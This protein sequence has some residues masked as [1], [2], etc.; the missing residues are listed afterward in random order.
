M[1]PAGLEPASATVTECR[2]PLTLR[3]LER[4]FG[5]AANMERLAETIFWTVLQIGRLLLGTG[6]LRR[7]RS[8]LH[9]L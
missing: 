8:K 9:A 7:V 2:V 3:A 1:D 4:V 6:H 5:S